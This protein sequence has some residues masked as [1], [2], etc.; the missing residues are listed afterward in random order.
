MRTSLTIAAFAFVA[1]GCSTPDPTV[2]RPGFGQNGQQ[3]S[4][5][6]DA[7]GGSSDASTTADSGVR[8]TNDASSDGPIEGSHEGGAHDGGGEGGA[9]DGGGEGG[10]EAGIDAGINAFS[11]APA[12]VATTGPTTLNGSHNFAGGD[13]ANPAGHACL[14]CHV[15]GGAAIPFAFGGTVWKDVGATQ[16]APQVQVAL[17]DNNGRTFAVYTDGAGNFFAYA[18]Q[19]GTLAPPELTGVRTATTTRLMTGTITSGN[20]NGCHKNGGQTPINLQ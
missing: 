10:V 13:P 20:C 19:V 12:Y 14:D 1:A 5:E 4:I 9:H 8:A 7:G 3:G 16:P 17:R 18:S 15:T 11:G 2:F 6:V